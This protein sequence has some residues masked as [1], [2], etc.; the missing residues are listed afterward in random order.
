M[1]DMNKLG[2]VFGPILPI[3]L[4]TTVGYSTVIAIGAYY[5][6]LQKLSFCWASIFWLNE[7][8]LVTGMPD[9]KLTEVAA[10]I[11]TTLGKLPYC[12]I[13]LLLFP[14]TITFIVNYRSL[15]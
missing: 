1:P 13:I 14:G 15:E 3:G 4:G 7:F 6:Y 12:S 10:A 2:L 5:Q 11:A 9:T 8:N